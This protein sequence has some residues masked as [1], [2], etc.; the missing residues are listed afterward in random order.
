MVGIG[1]PASRRIKISS[2]RG[3]TSAIPEAL[4]VPLRDLFPPGHDG[5]ARNPKRQQLESELWHI[6]GPLPDKT[7]EIA[8]KQMRAL[9]G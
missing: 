4:E 1:P 3:L 7:L 9:K 2:A 5:K 6:V 8:L